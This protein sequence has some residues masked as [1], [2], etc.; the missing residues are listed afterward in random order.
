MTDKF[1]HITEVLQNR[2]D[3]SFQPTDAQKRAKSQFWSRLEAQAIQVPPVPDHAIAARLVDDTA[4][5]AKWWPQAGFASWFWNRNEF[6]ESLDF[7][8]IVGL[9]VLVRGLQSAQTPFGQK[10]PAIKLIMELQGRIGKSADDSGMLDERIARMSKTELE[11]YIG[12]SMKLVSSPEKELTTSADT[13]TL[14]TAK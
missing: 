3:T 14:P 11:E 6:Q 4:N 5:L 2:A 12:K 8:A 7:A 1:K 9:E 10:V 13:D